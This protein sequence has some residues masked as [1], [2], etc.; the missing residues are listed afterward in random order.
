[1]VS[2]SS[3]RERRSDA[4]TR[5]HCRRSRHVVT[6]EH[7][8]GGNEL[9]ERRWHCAGRVW[10]HPARRSNGGAGAASARADRAFGDPRC[11]RAAALC[12]H[13]LTT[14]RPRYR[15]SARRAAARQDRNRLAEGGSNAY[16]LRTDIRAVGGALR[17]RLTSAAEALVVQPRFSRVL[18]ADG[19][20]RPGR[21]HALRK[22]EPHL[23]ARAGFNCRW[24]T[25]AVSPIERGWSRLHPAAGFYESP[26]ISPDGAARRR[27]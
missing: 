16:Y 21:A 15:K 11:C 22:S 9:E 10:S 17:R 23:R 14:R 6:D 26:R 12:L 20:H 3:L 2:R 13:R 25:P 18:N 24:R 1:M 7:C 19:G 4:Q 5:Q 8:S 27:H